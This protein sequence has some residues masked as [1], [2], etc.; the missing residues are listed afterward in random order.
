MRVG[1][2]VAAIGAGT[3]SGSIG[4]LGGIGV[5]IYLVGVAEGSGAEGADVRQGHLIVL[6]D[7]GDLIDANGHNVADVDCVLGARGTTAARA[8][9]AVELARHFDVDVGDVQGAVAP[10]VLNCL[11]A[12]TFESAV[13]NG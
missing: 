13:R 5:A 9:R 7:S 11:V 2:L 1:A 3:L 4:S 8:A 6:T 10:V 12:R